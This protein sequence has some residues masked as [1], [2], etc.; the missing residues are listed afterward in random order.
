MRKR[1]GYVRYALFC[2]TD[3][4]KEKHYFYL[5]LWQPSGCQTH[6]KA[7]ADSCLLFSLRQ[8]SIPIHNRS[9]TACF[10]HHQAERRKKQIFH[11]DKKRERS[12]TTIGIVGCCPGS[13][14][15]H[16]AVAISCF[17]SSKLRKKT[18]FLELHERNEISCLFSDDNPFSNENISSRGGQIAFCNKEQT[19]AVIHRGCVDYYPNVA[20]EHVPMLLNRGY[21]YLILDLGS[22]PEAK[23]SEF[24]R[25]D[26]KLVLGSLAPWK[27]PY[28]KNFMKEYCFG[29][30]NGPCILYFVQSGS[31]KTTAL[32]SKE[33]HISMQS[34][35][36]IKNPF[37]IEKELFPFLQNVVS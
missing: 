34:I 35:P 32:F 12:R 27:I 11:I 6:F 13:G 25:C 28:Y 9:G 17:C 26:I 22:S 10:C 29:D 7:T 24:L 3:K 23:K 18:A 21:E 1:L 20:C 30:Q 5:Q 4:S 8:Q 31:R 36:F 15:T 16:L 2:T 37:Q 14:V 19:D 33:Y